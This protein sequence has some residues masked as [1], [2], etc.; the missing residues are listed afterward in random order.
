MLKNLSFIFLRKS[1]VLPL[2]IIFI[3]LI[4]ILGYSSSSSSYSSFSI[5]DGEEGSL[6]FSQKYE[7][8]KSSL[9]NFTKSL[10]GNK[11][12]LNNNNNN[13][14]DNNKQE[15]LYENIE[16]TY[17]SYNDEDDEDDEDDEFKDIEITID[18]KTKEQ[19]DKENSESQKQED[20]FYD[21]ANSTLGFQKLFYINIPGRYDLDDT[22]TMQSVVS[23]IEPELYTGA[24]KKDIPEDNVGLP[25]YSEYPITTNEKACYRSHANIWKQMLEENWESVL[26]LEAD[27][28][29]DINIRKI[30]YHFSQGLEDLMRDRGF[31]DPDTHYSKKDPYLVKYWDTLHFGGCYHGHRRNHHSLPYYDPY[32]PPDFT[33]FGREVKPE[34]RVVRFRGEEVCTT[35]YAVT[36]RGAMKLLSRYNIDMNLPIDVVIKDMIVDK[37]LDQ[38]TVLPI[39]FAQWVYVE[40][41]GAESKNSDVRKYKSSEKTKEEVE[42][43]WSDI[44]NRLIIW[45]YI[46]H[47]KNANFRQGSLMNLKHFFFND[48]DLYNKDSYINKIVNNNEEHEN[49]NNNN[50]SSS[51]EEVNNDSNDNKNNNNNQQNKDPKELESAAWDQ[52]L[53]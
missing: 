22:I 27:A 25:P 11:K 44:H 24:I 51:N 9:T 42:K 6:D 34:H 39:F 28:T 3:L 35:A 18:G 1:V 40:G 8:Y 2:L 16:Y 30:F 32:A 36:K 33:Y 26:I 15:N 14:E 5:N 37:Q 49:D 29:W 17:N 20:E 52:G 19:E 45:D 41:I 13:N 53:N 50:T 7:Y 46:F 23:G 12:N 48:K 43:L 21:I 38:Y 4:S 10:S 47:Q 31:I